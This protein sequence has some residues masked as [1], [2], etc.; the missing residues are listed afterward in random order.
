MIGE[1]APLGDTLYQLIASVASAGGLPQTATEA[2]WI[3]IKALIILHVVLINGLWAVWWERKISAHIQSR[4]GPT[5]AGGFHGWAQTIL[6]GIKLL[7]K[8]DITPA[9]AD[10]WVHALA[11][12]IV[13]V[14][15]IIAFAPVS[16]G[17]QLAAADIDVGV[18]YIFAFAGISVIGVVMGGWASGNKYS[19][20][21]GLRA[22]A[23]LVS[24]ELPRGFSVVP[25]IMFSGSLDLSV[26]AH[27]QAGY[28]L[29]F[30]PKWFIFYPLVGQLAFIIFLIASVAETNRTPFDIPEAESELV[31]G[32]HT[33]YSGMK[34]SM[35]FLTE[36]GYVLLACFLLATFFLGGGAA[37]LP[38]LEII[39]SWIWMLGKAMA[40][41]FV[42]LWVR[43]TFPRFRA[44]QLMDF[45][46]KFLLP[47]S[48]ANIA[49]AAAALLYLS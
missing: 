19:L 36:Y 45:N 23:Q 4:V 47:W 15:V 7:L 14:P 25:V 21:G 9:V 28:W 1:L 2:T 6:D 5:Y 34:W 3:M 44:D 42:F 29:G 31:S 43:W 27:A 17:S 11:P 32:F 24:Y 20:L 35:F 38:G 33:E 40:M 37:P 18:L 22:T 48:F 12:A 13:V 16:F 10:K 49:F 39:P 46:W 26:I 41:M 8:E 30:I